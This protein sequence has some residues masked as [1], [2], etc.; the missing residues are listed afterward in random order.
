MARLLK[1]DLVEGAVLSIKLKENLYTIA[2]V[3]YDHTLQCFNIFREDDNWDGV[4]LN[5]EKHL[6][7]VVIATSVIL[8]LFKAKHNDS[9][10]AD[11]RPI[12]LKIIIDHPLT[13]IPQL[14][15]MDGIGNV[16]PNEWKLIV[17]N[18]NL[19]DHLDLI[20]KYEI[21]A[22][23][24]NPKDIKDR[25]LRYYNTGINFDDQKKWFFP[26]LDLDN[27]KK[28]EEFNFKDLY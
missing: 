14:K 28:W 2:Q 22:M 23:M 27:L 16:S 24:G 18:L 26:D 20:Y 12:P 21:T 8:K 15:E 5:K 6:F 13:R 3:K 1:K 19:K 4:D 17:D 25:L 11:K 10:I 9:V 7:C